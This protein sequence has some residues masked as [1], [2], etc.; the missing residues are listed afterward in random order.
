MSEVQNEAKCTSQNLHL[1][2]LDACKA[3][4]VV[5]QES[6]LRKIYL[7]GVDGSLLT[8]LCSLYSDATSSV[9][10]MGRLSSPFVI[11]QGVRQGG[12]LSTLHYKLFNND[13][14][15]MLESLGLGAFIG[16]INWC[17]PTCADDVALLGLCKKHLWELLYIVWFYKGRERYLI[18]AQKSVEVL[19]GLFKKLLDME[20][21]TLDDIPIPQESDT[22][23]LGVSRNLKGNGN[24]EKKAQIGRRTMYALMGAGAYGNSGLNPLVSSKMW[25]TFALP[26]M[27]YGLEV[28]N[29]RQA[30]IEQL[31]SVQRG[32]LRRIQCLPDRVAIAAVYGLLGIRPIEQEL[33]IRKLS[34]FA[35][36]MFDEASLEHEI[37]QRQFA[38]KDINSDSWFMQ[39]NLLLHKY[40]LSNAYLVKDSFQ[41]KGALKEAISRG[42]DKYVQQQWH[43]DAQSKSTLK[44]LNI[45]HCKVGSVHNVWKLTSHS[46]RDVRRAQIKVKLLTG[47]YTLQSSRS[48]FSKSAISDTCLLC[49]VAPED[50]KHFLLDCSRLQPVRSTYIHDIEQ[51]L[52]RVVPDHAAQLLTNK[53][54]LC[55]VIM[56]CTILA[57]AVSGD[58]WEGLINDMEVVSRNLCFAL[59]LKRTTLLSEHN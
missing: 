47:S 46:T 9:K 34:L 5:W 41:T 2:T 35:T 13:L 20:Q 14:L 58:L 30:D 8:T 19:L 33:D 18:N 56:D 45:D 25:K 23:H 54:R 21:V 27:L 38:V 1:I 40:G 48:K 28:C 6:L 44:Y 31:E 24:T 49:K 37:A 11:K 39:C 16:H 52:L 3:F 50:L 4:D 12:V 59:H 55:C 26:R 10:W 29:L 17:A 36:V 57:D 42:V 32:I 22:V 7:A 51:I 53:E 43:E 15:H